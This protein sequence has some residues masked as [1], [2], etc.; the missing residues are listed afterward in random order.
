VRFVVALLLG[1]A[2]HIDSVR[3]QE[4][5]C[6]DLSNLNDAELASY[7]FAVRNDA[8]AMQQLVPDHQYLTGEVRVVIQPIFDTSDPAEDR[9]LFRWA[10]RLH[11]N[12][13]TEL[14]EAVILF[15]PGEPVKVSTL[16]ESERILRAKSYLYDARVIPR[17]LCGDR[18]DVDVVVREVWT[19]YPSF[20]FSRSGGNNAYEYGIIDTN[21]LGTGQTLSMFFQ[22]DE[23]RDGTGVRYENPNVAGSR[24]AI[25]TLLENNSDGSRYVVDVGQP[26]YGLDVRRALGARLEDADQEQGLYVLGDKFAEFRQ[27]YQQL[28]IGGGIS[29]GE[30]QGRTFRWLAGYAYE[31]HKF[32]AVPGSVPPD[33]LPVDRTLGY[34]WIGFAS[35]E[36]RF[37]T[38]VNVDRIYRTEDLDLGR[39]YNALLGWSDAAFGGDDTS[40]LV[41]RADYRDGIRRDDK[42]LLFYGVNLHG[43]WNFDLDESEQVTAQAYTTYRQQQTGRFSLAGTLRGTVVRNLPTDLQLLGGGDTGLRGYPSRYQWGNRS[44]LFSLEERYFSDI[45]IARLLRLGFAM[46]VDAGRTW[47]SN[48]PSGDGFG[49]LA[50]V[51]FGVRF[52]STR[53]RRDRV[54]HVDFAFPLVDGPGVQSMQILVVAEERF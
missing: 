51:G 35:I 41:L 2:L 23:D 45:Y 49:V 21:L 52:E 40:R 28:G 47:F 11:L 7:S 18:I 13:R 15:R 34:P 24:I 19:L 4:A 53:T 31:D 42:H 29:N 12:T 1:A 32:S 26:F 54:L 46:F 16:L 39:T 17:R 27:Q 48:G 20:D 8:A 25:D 14:I 30:H 6:V 43:Y 10:D 22:K 9:W 33:P 5:S 50:D 36:D 44:F 38:T 3:A 37:D